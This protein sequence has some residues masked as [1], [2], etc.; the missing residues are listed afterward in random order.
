M[1]GTP[2]EIDAQDR[3]ALLLE[4][5]VVLAA[6]E[7]EGRTHVE[8]SGA[9]E[10]RVRAAVAARLGGDVEVSVLAELPRTLEPRRCVGH[11]EREPGRLQLRYVL[12]GDEHMDDIVVAEDEERVVVLASVCTA[13][14]GEVRDG[15]ECP[16]HV[17]LGRPL[18]DRQVYDGLT[19]DPVP[20]KNVY[21]SLRG[22]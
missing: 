10:E 9:G 12:W 2:R 18:G 15:C 17:Y 5:I 13:A 8:V 3:A 20:F 11:M 22:L 1:T 4:G 19:G 6:E 21:E 14:A 7:A 16:F